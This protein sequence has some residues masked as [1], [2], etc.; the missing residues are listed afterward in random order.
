MT[1][2]RG[3]R[4]TSIMA[5]SYICIDC[6]EPALFKIVRENSN[7]P[8]GFMSGGSIS[9]AYCDKHLPPDARAAWND[10]KDC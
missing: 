7:P 4:L 2:Y 10:W 5:L 8:A 1:D 9:S 3:S 6:G